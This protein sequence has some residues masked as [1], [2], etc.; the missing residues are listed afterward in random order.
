MVLDY[1]ADVRRK[2]DFLINSE[3]LSALPV[4]KDSFWYVFNFTQNNKII[5]MNIEITEKSQQ[6]RVLTTRL[7]HNHHFSTSFKFPIILHG[8]LFVIY[9]Q[10]G[11]VD[12]Y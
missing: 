5:M 11:A 8:G 3:P 2:V 6:I 10:V 9:K 7:Y 12:V 1:R 4:K